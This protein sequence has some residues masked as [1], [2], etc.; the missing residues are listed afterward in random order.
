LSDVVSTDIKV[1]ATMRTRQEFGSFLN[2]KS[3]LGVGAEIGVQNGFFTRQ[4]LDQWKGNLL[5][6]IDI[7]QQLSD[8]EDVANVPSYE[9]ANRLICTVTQVS[10]HWQ[11]IRIIQETSEIAARLIPDDSLDLAYIDA[12][13]EYSAVINDLKTWLPK[14]KEGGIIAGHD[15]LDGV[16]HINGVKT[17]FGVRQ[18][19]QQFLEG[20]TIHVTEESFPTW[21]TTKTREM[22]TSKFATI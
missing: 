11:R 2:L 7:W 5:Y 18:A 8:Y 14:V 4:I 9:Q 21:F 19:V 15:Y 3:L 13:H 1:K 6:L 10:A 22:M 17:V 16:Y 20:H 12:N